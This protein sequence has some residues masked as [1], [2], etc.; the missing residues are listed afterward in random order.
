MS[1]AADGWMGSSKER[2]TDEGLKTQ[3]DAWAALPYSAVCL[4]PG[5]L[6]EYCPTVYPYGLRSAVSAWFVLTFESKDSGGYPRN[7]TDLFL[8]F[9]SPW[10]LFTENISK[11]GPTFFLGHLL[12]ISG[13]L[14]HYPARHQNFKIFFIDCYLFCWNVEGG[15]LSQHSFYLFHGSISVFYN[16]FT[17]QVPELSLG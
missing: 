4:H 8:L 11:L 10:V 7:L 14:N 13:L 16:V 15:S 9:S 5:A 12:L 1:L 3:G 17:I 6:V 2:E